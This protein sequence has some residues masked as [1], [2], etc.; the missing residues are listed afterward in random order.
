MGIW[1]WRSTLDSVPTHTHT[2]THAHTHTRT[3]T[4]THTHTHTHIHT[5]TNTQDGNCQVNQSSCGAVVSFYYNTAP[6]DESELVMAIAE[7]G[8]ISVAIDASHKS[9]T[10][11]SHGV[12]YEPACGEQVH[13]KKTQKL[14]RMLTLSAA[15]FLKNSKSFF[16]PSTIK[17]AFDRLTR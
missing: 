16:T 15:A 12:Y 9:F 7:H 8:P 13:S 3:Y 5:H 17:T 14:I 1:K 6:G 10:F 4:H 11:Y 2:C